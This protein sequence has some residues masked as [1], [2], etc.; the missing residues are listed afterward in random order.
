[1]KRVITLA[2]LLLLLALI[3]Q[4]IAAQDASPVA[5]TGT[6]SLLSGLGYPDLVVNTDGTTND[7]PAELPAGRYH[8]VLQNTNPTNAV[9]LDFYLPP[10]GTSVDD[11]I[12]IYNESVSLEQPPE[13]FYQ[14]VIPGGVVAL[15]GGTGEVLIDLAPGSWFAGIQIQSQD[16]PGTGTAQALTVTGT[17][18]E[19]NDPEGAVSVTLADLTVDL[20]DTLPA[21]PQIWK[22]SNTGSMPHFVAASLASEPLSQEQ[23]QQT[24]GMFIG[25]PLPADATPISQDAL[26]DVAATSVLSSGQSM[27]IEL[28][29]QPGQYLGACYLSGP[30]D[31]PMHAAMGM[32][33]IFTVE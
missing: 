24:L 26:T 12:A 5:G 8:V 33:K 2:T 1:M 14:L 15:P 3:P 13:L 11:A 6:A 18:P 9:E 27:W 7:L 4:G 22:V 20:P 25:T 30:G 21:G 17:M 29:L 31:L 16:G 19:L 10:D 28:D 23:V 32:F